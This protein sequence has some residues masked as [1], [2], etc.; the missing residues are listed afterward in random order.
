MVPAPF[1]LWQLRV[2]MFGHPQTTPTPMVKSVVFRCRAHHSS[3]T[4]S[5]T[6]GAMYAG[7]RGCAVL[8]CVS[9]AVVVA[10][11][12]AGPAVAAENV[13][14]ALAEPPE[15]DFFFFFFAVCLLVS[16]SPRSGKQVHPGTELTSSPSPDGLEAVQE[17]D[18]LPQV[19][20]QPETRRC[21]EVGDA[22]ENDPEYCHGEE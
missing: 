1:D 14:C 16:G 22:E 7:P 12:G 5:S 9:V 13:A 10:V 2:S 3:S 17:R 4:I 6:L 15:N 19:R 20:E 11:A 8:I 21:D 18:I